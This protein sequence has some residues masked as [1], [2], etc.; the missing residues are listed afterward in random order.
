MFYSILTLISALSISVIAAY[1]SIIGLATIFPGSIIS[2]AIMGTALEVGKIVAA[3]WL[4]RN[5]KR[6]PWLIKSYL[7]FGVVVLMGITSMGIFGFLSKSHITHKQEA[8]KAAALVSQVE[9]KIT[10]ENEFIER[11]RSLIA[12]VEQQIDDV[13]QKSDDFI[14]VEQNKIA[15]INQDLERDIKYDTDQLNVVNGRVAQLASEL[16]AAKNKSYGLFSDKK[17]IIEKLELEQATEREQLATQKQQ[18][19]QRIESTRNNASTAIKQIRA[20]IEQYQT[21]SFDTDSSDKAIEQYN[22]K[23]N[24]S[25]D[26]IDD[27][28]RQ[29]FDLNDGSAQLEAEVG[30]IKYVV[31]MIADLTGAQVSLEDAVRWMIMVLIVVFDP[32]AILLV[33]AAHI[34]LGNHN[35]DWSF[36]RRKKN[37]KWT[38][39]SSQDRV[40]K[41]N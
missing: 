6:A 38:H 12:Q 9:N 3:I 18:I 24:Q 26:K 8:D 28:E 25:L 5:W 30:P 1:F 37:Q 40:V 35:I 41:K 16:Q 21:A 34:S 10:R 7:V 33:I 29:K 27:L 32:L 31:E 17:K 20:R 19:E 22:I 39:K 2:V 4:H 11:Q 36:F 15:Q 14:Q 13:S 23:I